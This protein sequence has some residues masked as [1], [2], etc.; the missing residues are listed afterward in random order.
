MP[1]VGTPTV[2]QIADNML[3]ITGTAIAAN[4][5]ASIGLFG[6]Q[7]TPDLVLPETFAPQPY[8]YQGHIRG[9]QDVV[10]V[11]ACFASQLGSPLG[12]IAINKQ[13]TTN[14]NFLIEIAT[15]SMDGGPPSLEIYIRYHI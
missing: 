5:S 13:G 2:T 3:R 1:F 9:L 6:S 4:S 10:A 11:E 7:A 12:P 14:A 8:N 15:P